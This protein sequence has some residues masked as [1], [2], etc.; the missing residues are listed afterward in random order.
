MTYLIIKNLTLLY[1]LLFKVNLNIF[2]LICFFK[3]QK[4]EIQEKDKELDML[5]SNEK[6]SLEQLEQLKSKNNQLSSELVQ[7]QKKAEK[8]QLI[9]KG[10]NDAIAKMKRSFESIDTTLSCLS[11]LEY[12]K[13]PLTLV[14]GHS[15]CIN[16]LN[17]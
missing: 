16:V 14:C 5:K 8:M 9:K 10:I 17:I 1:K 13:D 2:K 7:N 3:D 6:V 4:Q 12:L 11:C 15:I